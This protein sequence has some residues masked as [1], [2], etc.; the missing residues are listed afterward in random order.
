MFTRCIIQI[1][2][3]QCLL[4]AY[5]VS[6]QR[7]LYLDC[8]ISSFFAT[9]QNEKFI[10][11]VSD[12]V[13]CLPFCLYSNLCGENACCV[14]ANIYHC[15]RDTRLNVLCMGFHKLCLVYELLDLEIRFLEL[16][17]SI[18]VFKVLGW[19]IHFW[20]FPN[21]LLYYRVFQL[22]ISLFEVYKLIS[23]EKSH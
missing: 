10:F 23:F 9:R 15:L 8:K 4:H 12:L 20:G 5:D 21:L 11:E 19:N 14:V 1:L 7:I 22:K 16:Q 18:L 17:T 6:G 3:L 13:A 2:S